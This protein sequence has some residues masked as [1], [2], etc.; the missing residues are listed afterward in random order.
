MN[1]C[2]EV[3]LNTYAKVVDGSNYTISPFSSS[4]Q[5][6]YRDA[7]GSA[8]SARFD[9]LI[10]SALDRDELTDWIKSMPS[11]L[12]N[13]GVLDTLRTHHPELFV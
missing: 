1:P 8:I 7:L 6:K 13:A 12:S 11:Y 10:L 9:A 5:R 3:Y 2:K 4:E